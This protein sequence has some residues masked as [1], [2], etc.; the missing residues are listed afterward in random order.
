MQ[1]TIILIK[2]V[3]LYIE[4]WVTMATISHRVIGLILVA[5]FG[6]V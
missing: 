3:M 6:F 2:L 4:V 1:E 5:N